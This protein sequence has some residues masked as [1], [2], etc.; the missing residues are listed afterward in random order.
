MPVQSLLFHPV[1][2]PESRVESGPLQTP[3]VFLENITRIIKTIFYFKSLKMTLFTHLLRRAFIGSV[4]SLWGLLIHL[5]LAVAGDYKD[6]WWNA[7]QSGM[8]FNLSQ[9]GNTVFGAW[10]FYADSG[11]P[12]FLTFSGEIQ[13]NRLSGA[14]YRNT[15]PA[16]SANYDASRVQS[17]AVGNAVM[18]FS[19]NDPHVARFEYAFEGKTGAIDLQRFSFVDNAPSLNKDFDGMVYGINASSGIP[20]NF[21]FSIGSGQFKLTR[22]ITTGSCVFEGTYVPQSEAVSARGSYRCTDLSA[23]TFVAPRLRVTPEGVYVG[24][25]TKTSSAGQVTNETHTGMGLASVAVLDF[26]GKTVRVSGS[27]SDCSNKDFRTQFVFQIT[28]TTLAFTGSDS[29]ITDSNA[30]DPNF[31]RSGPSVY[32]L[33]SLAELRAM[34]PSDPFLQCLPKCNVATFN[35]SWTGIDPDGRTYR[36]TFQHTPGTQLIYHTKQILQDPR[37]PGR[38]SFPL[39]SQIW[40]IE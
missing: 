39:G 11:Q 1:D 19:A 33:Y 15:G 32:E 3:A 26:T 31:C 4:F 14:L 20:A 17:A 2:D 8:G 22:E 25:I 30:S 29:T 21:N 28:A 24:Q 16:P 12:T 40:F 18:V 36:G 5:P 27:S 34:E 6:I 10:Y 23:G 13:N 7:S 37:Q 9:V 38:A 35:Q